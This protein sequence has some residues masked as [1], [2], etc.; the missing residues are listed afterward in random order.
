MAD[1][2]PKV[3]LT[4]A[5]AIDD[6]AARRFLTEQRVPHEVVS[7]GSGSIEDWLEEVMK[8][9]SADD[10]AILIV[11]A[12]AFD[13]PGPLSSIRSA[14]R[15]P[16][17]IAIPTKRIV[18]LSVP[19]PFSED[20]LSAHLEAARPIATEVLSFR[21][22]DNDALLAIL[23]E[24]TSAFIGT[25]PPPS[26]L[27]AGVASSGVADEA[28]EI[29]SLGFGPYVHAVAEFLKHPET[30][31][32]LTMSI[33]GPWGSG[34]SSFMR[35]LEAE[36][37]PQFRTI[38]FN[39]WRHEK[40][41]ELWAAFA[42]H[43]IEH[44]KP[45]KRLARWR[46]DARL[47]WRQFDLASGWPDLIRVFTWFLALACASI[48]LI[49]MTVVLGPRALTW[50]ATATEKDSLT[51]MLERWLG[52]VLGAGGWLA[53]AGALAALWQKFFRNVKSPLE[54]DLGK[55]LRRPDYEARQAFLERFQNDLS[56]ATDV[57]LDDRKK[58]FVFIDDLDRCELPQAAELMRAINLMLSD[59][60]PIVFIIG[61]DREKIAAALAV[62]HEKLFPY[63]TTEAPRKI[64]DDEIADSLQGLFFGYGFIEKFIQIPFAVPEP[65]DINI[66]IFLASLRPKQASPAQK[67]SSSDEPQSRDGGA[68]SRA[69]PTTDTSA[70]ASP[71]PKL[72]EFIRRL[73]TE[74]HEFA[75]LV[76][77]AAPAL[78]NNPR[79][80]KQFI[81]IFRLRVLI[82][83]ETGLFIAPIDTPLF[84]RLTLQKLAKFV[85]I[86][87]RWPLLLAHLD[88]EPDLI[89]NLENVALNTT[90]SAS[91]KTFRVDYWSRKPELMMLLR[92]GFDAKGTVIEGE[93]SDWL[94][95]LIDI[96]KLTRV[97][98]RQPSPAAVDVDVAA[99]LQAIDF[100]YLTDDH[101]RAVEQLL[102]LLPFAEREPEIFLQL[103]YHL[104]WSDPKGAVEY[105]RQGLRLRPDS[106]A[107]YFNLACGEAQ[108]GQRKEALRDL[109]GAV[110][111]NP[112][113]AIR[114][115]EL[116]GEDFTGLAS[117]PEF[118]SIIGIS[119]QPT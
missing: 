43:F 74:S 71:P 89:R 61:M 112:S 99:R 111:R 6:G 104:L 32:P 39:A 98:V 63:L 37:K 40:A 94:V 33:E 60:G 30:P 78:G 105:L 52:P 22:G 50:F 73:D 101:D 38:R 113:Y 106:A 79:R 93:I 27:E 9:G 108:L 118:L 116:V 11:P 114:A 29:D 13:A 66:D 54:I 25:L 75:K 62:K 87:L 42:L 28:S 109:R 97:S 56:D 24:K 103:G 110:K 41:E 100:L 88:N 69:Q 16:A 34:K 5:A 49:T 48:T 80:I 86:E 58:V 115:R 92:A 91:Q 95:G 14:K 2:Q 70:G 64:A 85:A 57:Y 19:S 82:A 55:Y 10:V 1:R 36:L 3:I 84:E 53:A 12:T 65:T 77:I 45:K 47:F 102:P 59:S 81:N 18:V 26:V 44:I 90:P 117:D 51:Q 67:Q 76:K 20:A 83:F 35:Q 46:S 96:A 68:A 4:V 107:G 119:G 31:A 72:H 7:F 23:R 15:L 21:G 8:R 17:E